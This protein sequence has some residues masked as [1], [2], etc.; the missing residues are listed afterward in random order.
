MTPIGSTSSNIRRASV[1]M[2]ATV[3]NRFGYHAARDA[4][5]EDDRRRP[6]GGRCGRVPAYH[7]RDLRR[8]AVQGL[9]DEFARQATP[10]ELAD[11]PVDAELFPRVEDLLGD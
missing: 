4:T 7:R 11:E 1:F 10:V 8:V 3:P 5:G 9:L 2:D 6:S